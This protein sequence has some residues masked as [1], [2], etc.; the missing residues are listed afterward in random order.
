MGGWVR[1]T[2]HQEGRKRVGLTAWTWTSQYVK[3]NELALGWV[4]HRLVVC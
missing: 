4:T 2:E 3:L 1:L